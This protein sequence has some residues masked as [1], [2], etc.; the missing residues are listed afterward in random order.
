MSASLPPAVQEYTFCIS[1]SG[2][3]QE[4]VGQRPKKH[5][6]YVLQTQAID[7]FLFTVFNGDQSQAVESL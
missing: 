2:L 3:G 7:T 6:R 4:Q 5:Q 1:G